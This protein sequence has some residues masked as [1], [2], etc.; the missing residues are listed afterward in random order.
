LFSSAFQVQL[1][2]EEATVATE[3]ATE[4]AIT[5]QEATEATDQEWSDM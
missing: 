1:M 3:V 4:V 2:Q 5:S